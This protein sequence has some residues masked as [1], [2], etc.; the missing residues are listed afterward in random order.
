MPGLTF[1][2]VGRLGLTSPP[3]SVLCS[4]TTAICSSRCPV[5]S[6]GHRY[7]G[8]TFR[9]LCPLFKLVSGRSSS[10]HAR[11]VWSTGFPLSS[12]FARQETFGS[13]KFPDYPFGHM[14]RSSTPVVSLM[15]A[16]THPGLLPS[17]SMRT[18][19][20]PP[21]TLT[22]ILAK[23]CLAGPRLYKFRG[24]IT[25][26]TSL[27]PLASDFRYR[28]YPQGSLLTCWLDFS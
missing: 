10:L 24:S 14:P 20:F 17:V 16:L 2:P 11:A 21:Y 12:G 4:A 9:C 6:L 23:L 26:P 8:T 1:P 15:L 13:L 19:A 28:T 5:L 27:L 3:S 22:V 25:Q 18:S 7:L